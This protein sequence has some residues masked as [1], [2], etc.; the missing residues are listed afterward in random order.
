MNT[1]K[2]NVRVALIQTRCTDDLQMNLTKAFDCIRL[3]KEQG[4]QIIAL[5]ELFRSLYFCQAEEVNQFE[6][7]ETIPGPT[8]NE[9]CALAQELNV[10]IVGS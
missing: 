6:L 1:Q 10:V 7:A 9:L 4:A 2:Q 5:Q 8:S 3:A